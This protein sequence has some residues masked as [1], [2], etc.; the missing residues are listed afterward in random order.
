MQSVDLFV[1]QF[2]FNASVYYL[3]RELGIWILGHNPIGMLGPALK[4]VT[5]VLISCLA[6]R[7][8][9]SPVSAVESALWMWATYLFLATTVH[10]WYVIPLVALG[11]LSGRV[12]PW[13]WSG[14]IFFSYSHYQ[15]GG[16]QEAYEWIAAQYTLLAVTVVL[17]Y[18]GTLRKW[19]L[20]TG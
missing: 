11:T 9:H 10:P 6:L 12:W 18:R 15:G 1:S 4:V 3:V 19:G 5:V 20:A 17:E 16:F 8:H 13:I 2:E 14:L 7:R